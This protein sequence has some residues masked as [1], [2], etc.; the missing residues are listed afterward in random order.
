MAR[1]SP[2]ARCRRAGYWF[3]RR[4]RP[5]SRPVGASVPVIDGAPI[6]RR[7]LAVDPVLTTATVPCRDRIPKDVAYS[8]RCPRQRSAACVQCTTGRVLPA[9]RLSRSCCLVCERSW[10]GRAGRAH[11]L[12]WWPRGCKHRLLTSQTAVRAYSHIAESR[13]Q[14]GRHKVRPTTVT[15]APCSRCMFHSE[16]VLCYAQTVGIYSR[17]P[18]ILHHTRSIDLS[19]LVD[20]HNVVMFFAFTAALRCRAPD[21]LHSTV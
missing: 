21:H 6:D 3:V 16:W 7:P 9:G 10:A 12:R 14:L 15:L 19:P 5:R 2:P 1:I 11:W 13:Q 17:P 20:A 8:V 18:L 4:A